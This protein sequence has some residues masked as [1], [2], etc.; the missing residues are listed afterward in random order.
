[1]PC[2]VCSMSL[3]EVTSFQ[4]LVFYQFSHLARSQAEQ[5][6]ELSLFPWISILHP[7]NF[8]GPVVILCFKC[9]FLFVRWIPLFTSLLT[10]L[11]FIAFL[12]STLLLSI[13][14]IVGPATI[15]CLGALSQAEQAKGTEG[16]IFISNGDL[17]VCCRSWQMYRLILRLLEEFWISCTSWPWPCV[18]TRDPLYRSSTF[19][20]YF[21]WSTGLSGVQYHR[22]CAIVQILTSDF[23]RWRLPTY[24]NMSVEFVADVCVSPQ[25]DDK[26]LNSVFYRG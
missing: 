19:T 21:K 6:I 1:M 13:S 17:R 22:T 5:V 20:N 11:C 25:H 7:F 10:I 23:V 12:G 24:V 16:S 26:L 14:N 8:V 2:F 4:L 15:L 18:A 3:P 9:W